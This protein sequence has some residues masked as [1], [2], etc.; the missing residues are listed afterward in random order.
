VVIFVDDL[1]RC[2]GAK[3]LDVCEVAAQLLAHGDV[4]TVLVADLDVIAAAAAERYPWRAGAEQPD[5]LGERY[6]HKVVQVR[7]NLPPLTPADVATVLARHNPMATIAM[8]R[9]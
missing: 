4:V 5:R 3:A 7:F 8:D 1:E 9:K 2:P 6:L